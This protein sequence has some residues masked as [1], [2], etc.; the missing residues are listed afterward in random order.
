ML[1]VLIENKDTQRRAATSNLKFRLNFRHAALISKPY[2]IGG[3][4]WQNRTTLFREIG[5]Q[6]R[7]LGL[8]FE[9]VSQ[10]RVVRGRVV[11][12]DHAGAGRGLEA[13]RLSVD[14]DIALGA[15]PH[16]GAAKSRG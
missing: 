4:S 7:R 11:A 9:V 3:C 6:S 12:H 16:R 10:D 14:G 2:G 8:G 1:F 5:E 13:E 15:D